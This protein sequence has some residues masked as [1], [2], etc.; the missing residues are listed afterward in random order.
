M[1]LGCFRA[2]FLQKCIP[3]SYNIMGKAA[4]ER[5]PGVSWCIHSSVRVSEN[6]VLKTVFIPKGEEVT[7]G[8][9][10]CNDE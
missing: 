10:N 1:R 8:K 2:H 6:R 5:I 7:R 3:A 4:S 9:R